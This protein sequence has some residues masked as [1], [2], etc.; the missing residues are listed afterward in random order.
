MIQLITKFKKIS[1]LL[2]VGFMIAAPF[3]TKAL[4]FNPTGSDPTGLINKTTGNIE[5]ITLG[6]TSPTFVALNLINVALSLL[7]AL[8]VA[9]LLYAGFLWIWAR[10]NAEEVKKAKDIIVGTVLGLI[11]VLASLGITQF[12]FTTVANITGATVT[13]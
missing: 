2:L 9:L 11:I 4:F 10:G 1:L 13:S 7:A 3:A 12:V 6:K 5:L 8:C